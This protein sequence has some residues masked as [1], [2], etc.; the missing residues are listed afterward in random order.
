MQSE[1]TH[2]T[3]LASAAFTAR[4]CKVRNSLRSAR[5]AMMKS[6]IPS[7]LRSVLNEPSREITPC[8]GVYIISASEG[9]AKARRLTPAAPAARAYVLSC[10]WSDAERF[11][12]LLLG[13]GDRGIGCLLRG[14]HIV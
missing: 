3:S 13:R 5:S 6:T 4:N 1:V 10:W 9:C 2:F 8:A 12:R 14:R 7:L 11:E